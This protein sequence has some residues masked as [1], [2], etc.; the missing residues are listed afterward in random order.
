MHTDNFDFQLHA[1]LLNTTYRKPRPKGKYAKRISFDYLSILRSP[2]FEAIR[3]GDSPSW[4]S[5]VEVG[6]TV[7]K[8]GGEAS[9]ERVLDEDE[10]ARNETASPVA[11]TILDSASVS[12]GG[13][14]KALPVH[15]DL[16][17]WD[18]DEL[19]IC[20]MGS[21]GPE[22][23]YACAGRISLTSL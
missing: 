12:T 15:V 1:T 18:V 6:Q 21:F 3:V 8:H 4:L 14:V 11:A 17:T 20:E 19:Q 5:S 22:G 9:K 23:E 13:K 2:A 16:G 7:P 10:E